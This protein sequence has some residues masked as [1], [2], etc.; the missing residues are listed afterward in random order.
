MSGCSDYDVYEGSGLHIPPDIKGNGMSYLI[1]LKL[2][3]NY[4]VMN[5]TIQPWSSQTVF[6]QISMDLRD[7]F[8][9]GKKCI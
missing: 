6:A 2:I 4:F 9:W 3:F 8:F 5:Y 1:F 7:R